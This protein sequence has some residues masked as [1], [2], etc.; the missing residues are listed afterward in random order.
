MV[1]VIQKV[2]DLVKYTIV[3]P[4]PASDVKKFF[5]K[6]EKEKWLIEDVLLEWAQDDILK[7]L[8]VLPLEH[9]RTQFT[10]MEQHIPFIM[11]LALDDK[12]YE[13]VFLEEVDRIKI[14]DIKNAEELS[15]AGR[16]LVPFNLKFENFP[17][18]YTKENNTE[19][20]K[21]MPGQILLNGVRLVLDKTEGQGGYD[22][23]IKLTGKAAEIAARKAR[24]GNEGN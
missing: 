5:A 18:K 15:G 6:A 17:L 16:V 20:F 12:K 3:H 14:D 4:T 19:F 24:D 10:T 21:L 2:G 9:Y 13:L 22:S 23:G 11:G 1:E 7:E 8:V